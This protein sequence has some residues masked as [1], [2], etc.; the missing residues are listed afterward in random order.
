MVRLT[1]RAKANFRARTALLIPGLGADDVGPVRRPPIS[2]NDAGMRKD[3]ANR[4]SSN[5][6]E[7][8]AKTEGHLSESGIHAVL[9]KVEVE[10]DRIVHRVISAHLF[11]A[12]GGGPGA[13]RNRPPCQTPREDR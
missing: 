3:R 8:V 4:R 5:R 12:D 2:T 6:D 1:E 13:C 10:G 11:T 9:L 7:I